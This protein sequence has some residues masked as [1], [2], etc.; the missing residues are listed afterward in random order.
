[1]YHVTNN[2]DTLPVLTLYL[3]SYSL[4]LL[5]GKADQQQQQP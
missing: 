5:E 2:L 3:K 1:M 4:A